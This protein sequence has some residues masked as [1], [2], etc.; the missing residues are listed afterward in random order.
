MFCAVVHYADCIFNAGMGTGVVEQ[1]R[2]LIGED[3]QCRREKEISGNNQCVV[4]NKALD[5]DSHY[6]GVSMW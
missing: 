6:E 2:E 1:V 5:E 4:L 3:N